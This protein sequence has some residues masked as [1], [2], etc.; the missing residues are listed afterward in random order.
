MNTTKLVNPLRVRAKCEVRGCANR[1]SWTVGKP[2]H[3]VTCVHYCTD[4]LRKITE[5]AQES[6]KENIAIAKKGDKMPAE[7]S[8]AEETPSE[9]EIADKSIS[10]NT[11]LNIPEKKS[12]EDS[13]EE[14][15]VC[16]HCGVT[17]KKPD[18]LNDYRK[19]IA[20]CRNG[21]S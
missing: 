3:K 12:S 21:N 18:E 9:E 8:S 4:C 10:T 17:F 7:S 1:A 13:S 6:L 15:Y 20:K 14:T 19:H 16:K 5:D 11:K 2:S